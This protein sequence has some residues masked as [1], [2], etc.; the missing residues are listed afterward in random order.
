MRLPVSKIY[1][2]FPELDPFTDTECEMYV[3]RARSRK[4]GSGCL[5]AVVAVVAGIACAV[6]LPS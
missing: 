3:A 6:V 5:M 4:L 1:R 2:G